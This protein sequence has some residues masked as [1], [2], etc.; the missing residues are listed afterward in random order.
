MQAYLNR[1]WSATK[2]NCKRKRE[3]FVARHVW[4]A[5][6]EWTPRGRPEYGECFFFCPRHWRYYVSAFAAYFLLLSVGALYRRIICII[7]TVHLHCTCASLSRRTCSRKVARQS[8]AR[9]F[10]HFELAALSALQ[11]ASGAPHNPVLLVL[12][13]V[14]VLLLVCKARPACAAQRKPPA[15]DC[16]YR[17]ITASAC[18]SLKCNLFVCLPAVVI[19]RQL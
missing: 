19:A 7:Y 9:R 6:P 18:A 14:L 2:I 17:S 1:D 10:E 16:D 3:A 4:Q 8:H 11:F 15:R 13:P 5:G 12:L